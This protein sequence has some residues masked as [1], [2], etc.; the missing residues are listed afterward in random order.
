MCHNP[1]IM[2][3]LNSVTSW[4]RRRSSGWGGFRMY[5]ANTEFN[6]YGDYKKKVN[7]IL[8]NPALLK[9]FA[10][11]CDLFSLGRIEVVQTVNGKEKVIMDDP[12]LE[13][14]T[15]P[16]L[17]QTKS[18][19]LWD[20]MF[21]NMVGNAYIYLDSDIATNMDNKMYC[22]DASKI[23]FPI[24]LKQMMDKIILSKASEKAIMDQTITYRYSDGTSISFPL[25]RLITISD[26]TNGIGNWLK[27]PSRIDALY[28]VISNTEAAL[29][30]TNINTRF[31]GKFMVAGTTDANDVNRLMLSK[32]EREDIED[33]AQ[34]PRE[35]YGVKSLVE[36]KRFVEDIG[37]L[38]LDETYR[39]AYFTIANMYGIPKEV[40]EAYLEGSTFENQ[41]KAT[42]R[43]VAYTLEP[44][45]EDIGARIAKR[46]KYNLDNKKIRISWNHLMFMQVFRS[47][48]AKANKII[49]DTF[50][51]LLDQGV[52]LQEVNEFLGTKFQTGEKNANPSIINQ[53]VT[54]A[55]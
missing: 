14:F 50:K 18:Q 37:A 26:L 46:F 21:W 23:E 54:N 25:S 38:K 41:E 3:L 10:L 6:N 11:Q 43:H 8:S 30:A 45:G 27:S 17:F 20:I 4:F 53:P 48:Q 22:L 39:S 42:G 2:S 52:E 29:D 1:Y 13:I 49:A 35:V 19:I 32:D 40:A 15:N 28:K 44:K 47:E 24:E 34:G 16:N 5:G 36:V 55:A 9:V 7:A 51:V 12:A 31:S 33:K